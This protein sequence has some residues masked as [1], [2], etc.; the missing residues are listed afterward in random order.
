MLNKQKQIEWTSDDLSVDE[1]LYD[2]FFDDRD[3]NL[4]TDIH[5][6]SPE[7]LSNFITQLNDPRLKALLPLYKARNYPADLSSQER[8]DWEAFCQQRLMSG[9]TQSRLA[10]Y[11]QRITELATKPTTDKDQYLLEELRL[12]GESIMP[13]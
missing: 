9:K 5:D 13:V 10:R 3:K 11:M 12:Y 8:S 1:Q 6:A 4:M 7:T 2:G